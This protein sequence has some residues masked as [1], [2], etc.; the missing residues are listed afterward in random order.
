M[1][2]KNRARDFMIS[3]EEYPHTTASMARRPAFREVRRN[4]L[5]DAKIKK[6]AIAGF[7]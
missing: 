4:I 6:P 2:D 1:L 7:F 3:I 5:G